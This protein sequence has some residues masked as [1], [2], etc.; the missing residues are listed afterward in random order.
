MLLEENWVATIP[1]DHAFDLERILVFWARVLCVW[2]C[3]RAW[4]LAFRVWCVGICPRSSVKFHAS[5]SWRRRKT[6]CE[7]HKHGIKFRNPIEPN[8]IILM[9]DSTRCFKFKK[10]FCPQRT[11]KRWRLHDWRRMCL[12]GRSFNTPWFLF[13]HHR[14]LGRLLQMLFN[15]TGNILPDTGRGS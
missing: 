15:Q 1:K 10:T 5:D 8:G 6:F 7:H 2:G 12:D 13:T 4:G 11:E 9:Q 3:D 14:C